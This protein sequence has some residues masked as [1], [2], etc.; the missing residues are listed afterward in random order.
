MTEPS[1]G[2]NSMTE[3]SR[4]HPTRTTHAQALGSPSHI[5]RQPLPSGASGGRGSPQRPV[6]SRSTAKVCQRH[7]DSLA[8]EPFCPLVRSSGYQLRLALDRPTAEDF[9]SQQDVPPHRPYFSATPP[10]HGNSRVRSAERVS[11]RCRPSSKLDRHDPSTNSL[12]TTALKPTSDAYI[13]LAS[14]RKCPELVKLK[15]TDQHLCSP[16]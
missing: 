14:P 7:R 10:A 5:G 3:P 1:G 13:S 8:S 16:W 9:R 12:V 6:D 15:G 11:D 2:N 4:G